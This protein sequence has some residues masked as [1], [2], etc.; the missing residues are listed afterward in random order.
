MVA[1]SESTGDFPSDNLVSNE[2][3]YLDAAPALAELAGRAYV[4]V[5]PEQNLS[6]I[7]IHRPAVAYVV[8]IRR[9]N[10]LLHLAI[11]AA[12]EGADSRAA[13]LAFL[14]SREVPVV[15]LD[16]AIDDVAE[17][18][19][20]ARRSAAL[21]DAAVSRSAALHERLGIPLARRDRAMY[22]RIH[23]SFFAKGLDLAYTMEGSARPYPP[24]RELLASKDPSGHFGSFLADEASYRFVREFVVANRLV[25]VVGDFAGTHALRAIADDVRRRGLV[26]GAFYA[27]NVE[28]YL[29]DGRVWPAFADNLRALP[30]DERSIVVRTWFDRGRPHPRQRPGHRSATLTAP[31]AAML[32]GAA[33]SPP[34]SYWELVTR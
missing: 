12:M 27:S 9:E 10:L 1:L 33:T 28:E 4:G 26:V 16:A 7:A 18:I 21:R 8:D 15:A 24:L 34:R 32:E 29:F 23:Q 3:A 22:V 31:L 14:T 11:R 2:T 19:G 17:A 25:P 13:F 20:G 30:L 5:G 6:Y